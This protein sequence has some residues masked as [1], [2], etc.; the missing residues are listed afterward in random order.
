MMLMVRF[1]HMNI[2]PLTMKEALKI[3]L[4]IEM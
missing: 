4:I 2:K 1:L 3:N